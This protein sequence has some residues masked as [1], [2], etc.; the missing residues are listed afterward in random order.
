MLKRYV[1][2]IFF[3]SVFLSASQYPQLAPFCHDECSMQDESGEVRACSKTYNNLVVTNALRTSNLNVTSATQLTG[4]TNVNGAMNVTGSLTINGLPI[5]GGLAN[6]G[7]FTNVDAVL[8]E[9]IDSTILWSTDS[10]ET[11]LAN[12]SNQGFIISQTGTGLIEVQNTGIYLYNFGV[13][14]SGVASPDDAQVAT[15]QLLLN[16]SPVTIPTAAVSSFTI[17]VNIDATLTPQ[18]YEL[19]SSGLIAITSLPATLALSINLT[20]SWQMAENG[21]SG[22]AYITLIQVN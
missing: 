9:N 13:V 2:I 1:N 8:A 3:V 19:T 12:P 18:P 5:A 15:V 21:G 22:N 7:S 16:G 6:F 14:L 20:P 11:T 4:A 17:P 10:G